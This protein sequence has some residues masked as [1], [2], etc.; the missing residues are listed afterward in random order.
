M[1][2][3][4][5]PKAL[6]AAAADA[7][8]VGKG[9]IVFNVKD[10]GAVGNNATD[11]TPFINAAI[12]AA[13]AVGDRAVLLLPAAVGFRTTATITVPPN[14]DLLMNTPIIYAG[15][16]GS[17]AL[18]IGGPLSTTARAF[19]RKDKIKVRRA[20]LASW[21]NLADVGVRVYN[22]YWGD[23]QFPE[24]VNFT[25]GIQIIGD[26]HGAAYNNVRLGGIQDCRY[27][28]VLTNAN[29]GWANEN[30]FIGGSFTNAAAT[31]PTIDRVG[32][33]ITSDGGA[34]YNNANLFIK[35]SFEVKG[36]DIAA[37]GLCVLAE[38]GSNNTIQDARHESPDAV[39]LRQ[40]NN[41][42][43]N[44]LTTLFNIAGTVPKADD[45]GTF[46]GG[47]IEPGS[48]LVEDSAKRLIHKADALHKRA[49]YYDGATQ[50][51]VPGTAIVTSSTSQIISRGSSTLVLDPDFLQIPG[52]RG[53][54]FFMSTRSM[55]RFTLAADADGLGGRWLVQAFD[56]AGAP[57]TAA[58]TVRSTSGNPTTATAFYGGWR[59]GTDG[60]EAKHFTVSAAVDYVF[61]G[62]TGGT[63]VAKIRSFSA[64]ALDSHAVPS[65][66]LPWF[67]DG[68]NHGTAAP[69]A[70]TWAVGRRVIQDVPA[71]GSPKGWV[72]TV[73]GTP[74]TWVSEG[75][76]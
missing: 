33:H 63:A 75:N 1:T 57:V 4:L 10:Y 17:P 73:A 37:E 67:E 52:G 76:L 5:N 66:W 59:T 62:V 35:P 8:Y 40:L 72:C 47:I 55:K 12:T 58:G 32:I 15:P 71:V 20:T 69:T 28:V 43:K 49:C 48:T 6:T 41:S 65:T 74:G 68:M 38:Y 39:S 16:A 61:V 3:I 51:N 31:H 11:D 24:V 70:G 53:I 25:V 18:V 23:L 54:G 7:T 9:S 22:S 34:Y 36:V 21:T 45:A 42:V 14:V 44:K 50:I 56:I 29:G 26:G 19:R 60:L 27:G 46:A 30:V 2:S 13:T 64:Y